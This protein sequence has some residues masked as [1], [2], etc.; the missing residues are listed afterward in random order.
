L[1]NQ[2]VS[3]RAEEIATRGSISVVHLYR[4]NL[5]RFSSSFILFKLL[6]N[7]CFA[8]SRFRVVESRGQRERGAEQF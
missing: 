7:F 3:S 1:E 4:K 8:S 5:I 2:K 6:F